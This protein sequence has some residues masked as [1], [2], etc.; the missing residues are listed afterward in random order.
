MYEYLFTTLTLA[1]VDCVKY[2]LHYALREWQNSPAG[3]YCTQHAEDL[4]Y[5]SY[6]KDY[7]YFVEITGK[8]Q[9]DQYIFYKL[10]EQ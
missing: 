9:K 1:D 8:M 2:S 4:H 6:D 3:Q 7:Q 10:I 5:I